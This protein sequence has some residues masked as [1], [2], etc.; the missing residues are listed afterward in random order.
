MLV[1]Q[2]VGLCC[3]ET[4]AQATG[5]ALR[6]LGEGTPHSSPW[7]PY[8]DERWQPQ[9]P[10]E[11]YRQSSGKSC[12]SHQLYRSFFLEKDVQVGFLNGQKPILLQRK[13]E[14]HQIAV[15]ISPS[16]IFISFVFIMFCYCFQ[17]LPYVVNP[18]CVTTDLHLLTL[19]LWFMYCTL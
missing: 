7:L 17:N 3:R 14:F 1:C 8:S 15:S 12:S 2:P 19:T 5:A 16:R 11:L 4:H 10:H 13:V 18:A 9:Q 6:R